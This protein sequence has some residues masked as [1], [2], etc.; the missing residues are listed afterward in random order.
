MFL[1]KSKEELVLYV[2]V[3]NET[4]SHM[5]QP[6]RSY[7]MKTDKMKKNQ[8]FMYEVNIMTVYSLIITTVIFKSIYGVTDFITIVS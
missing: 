4:P 1:L 6:R 8:T 7:H 5:G 3:A 2:C